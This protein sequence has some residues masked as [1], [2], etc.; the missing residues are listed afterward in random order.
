MFNL[1]LIIIVIVI[2]AAAINL[3]VM[4]TIGIKHMLGKYKVAV[5]RATGTC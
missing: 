3:A 4:S 2:F 5:V 1:E